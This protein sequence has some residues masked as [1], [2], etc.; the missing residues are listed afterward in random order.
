MATD[1]DT[2]RIVRSWL[3]E[4]RTALPDHIL[5][6]VLDQVPATRQRRAWWPAWRFA[7]MNNIAKLLIAAAAVAVVAIVG[8]NLLPAR[9]GG[10]GGGS[11]VSPSPSPSPA[12][13][14]RGTFTVSDNSATELDASGDG[15]NVTGTM[16][17]IDE[18]G[19]VSVDLACTRTT[20][21]GLLVVAGTVS[22]TTIQA[23]AE[24]SWFGIILRPGSPVRAGF[25]FDEM[26]AAASCPAFL[27]GDIDTEA[28][29]GL[30][31]IEG[32]VALAP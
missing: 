5:D 4:G 29:P 16:I 19:R 3:E 28:G 30:K 17:V 6:A 13:L 27:E 14:A 2:T 7:D 25:M 15:S 22:N 9:D 21:G 20:P 10:A 26:A 32:T 23:F 31:P 12:L 8:I 11:V 24:G 18:G 1:R